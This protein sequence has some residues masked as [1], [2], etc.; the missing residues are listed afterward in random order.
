MDKEV[1]TFGNLQTVCKEVKNILNARPLGPNLSDDPSSGPA[2]TPNHLL[3]AGRASVE[4]PQGDLQETSLNKKYIFIQNLVKE[5]WKKWYRSVFP[6]LI[7]SYKWRSTT[8]NIQAGDVILI[9][10]ENIT[11]GSYPLGK[12]LKVMKSDDDLVRKASVQ[13]MTG[14]KKKCVDKSVNALV[15]IIPVDYKHYMDTDI[16]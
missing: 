11:R 14:D 4:I 12:V 10:Q 15:V 3:L 7:P 8:R 6:T 9:Y 5:F 16:S 2:L 13:Y 1:L